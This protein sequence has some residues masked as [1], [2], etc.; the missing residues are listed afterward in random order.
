MSPVT[1]PNPTS[2]PY[3]RQ[4]TAG[5]YWYA[6]WSRNGRPVIRALGRTWVEPDDDGAW[7]RRRGRIPEGHLTE[8]MAH[9]RMLALVRE[10]DAQQSSLALDSFERGRQC[11]T[12][13]RV[14][15][16][17]LQWLRDIRGAKPST[18]PAVKSDLAEP[19]I[20]YRRG[21]GETRG[22]IMA[23]LGEPA[24]GRGDHARDQPASERDRRHRR[25]AAHRQQGTRAALGDLQRRHA[26]GHMGTR[27]QPRHPRRPPP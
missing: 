14:A 26:P 1:V 19:G 9:E 23:A 7:R 2:R 22:R 27:A 10:H 17:Y 20:G 6:K 13:R 12:F 3:L 8:A 18:V 21:K 11:V 4:R 16:D 15:H 24:G 25:Q 5:V